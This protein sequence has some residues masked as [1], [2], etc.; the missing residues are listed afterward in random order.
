MRWPDSMTRVTR[1]RFLS[2][3]LALTFPAAAAAQPT[4]R[5]YDLIIRGGI[6]IDPARG[7]QARTDV[8][9][10]GGRIAAIDDLTAATSARTLE[11][12]GRWVVPGL[13]DLQVRGSGHKAGLVDAADAY[14]R[15]SGVV[16]WVSAGDL[17]A[18][19]VERFRRDIRQRGRPSNAY[20]FINFDR[21]S[22]G[23]D[24]AGQR[25]LARTLAEHHD[26]VLGLM[27]RFDEVSARE[28]R[29]LLDAALELLRQAGTRTRLF[30]PLPASV[31]SQTLLEGLRP[32]D[33][34]SG[35]YNGMTGLIQDGKVHAG[36]AAARRRGVLID[37][38]VGRNFD[39]QIARAAVDQGLTPDVIS[40][41]VQLAP[42]SMSSAYT[43]RITDVVCAFLDLGLERDQ[44]LAMATSHPARVIGR[45][46]NL[47][48]LALDALANI[49]LLDVERGRGT[50]T[51][52]NTVA[53]VH[54]GT[55]RRGPA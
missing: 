34:V 50:V 30:C 13:V 33:I 18:E 4:P 46:S 24:A 26:V 41:A 5:T 36:V 44:V 48:T 37:A 43:P 8:G 12:E 51:R 15:S 54:N 28:P 31:V 10:R 2:T 53:T 32:G 23:R 14:A 9:I 17:E 40:S 16:A 20:A 45:D 42:A 35:L 39:A 47:G 27:L 11:A 55:L 7:L 1:R 22:A 25:A 29:A 6:V 52:I 38:G 49:A 3:C 19:D 21:R